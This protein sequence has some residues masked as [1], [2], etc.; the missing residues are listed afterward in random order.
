M[1]SRYLCRA[2]LIAGLILICVNSTLFASPVLSNFIQQVWKNNPAI[3]TAESALDVAKAQK[4]AAE[5]PLYN[6]EVDVDLE[7][8]D[9]NAVSVGISQS[10][11]LGNKQSVMVINADAR[12][13]L[14][15]AE[16]QMQKLALTEEILNALANLQAS[17]QLQNLAIQRVGLMQEFVK[18]TVQRHQAGDIG[19]QDVALTRVA[20]SEANIVL[21]THAVQHVENEMDL[22]AAMG[23]FVTEWP[24]LSKEPASV[25]DSLATDKYLNQLPSLNVFRAKLFAAKSNVKLSKAKRQ[26]DPSFGLRGGMEGSNALI[27]LSISMPLHI[28][29]SYRAEVDVSR[30]EVLR[31]EQLL[32]SEVHKAR[33]QMKGAHSRYQLIHKAWKSWEEAGEKNIS[34]QYEL[35]QTIWKSGEMSAAEYLVQAKQNVDARETAVELSEKMWKSWIAWL[36]AS[37]QIEQWLLHKVYVK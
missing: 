8:T 20:L 10:I 32:M 17:R 33:A 12:I 31:L 24:A 37:G 36:A 25:S 34:E 3:Q 6:P 7:R 21:A 19:L 4:I 26:A 14:A 23:S 30:F 27:G 1:T 29:N 35:I 11:D 13:Q 9:I 2:R 22:Q 18:N 16:L 15:E 28:R 5:Q